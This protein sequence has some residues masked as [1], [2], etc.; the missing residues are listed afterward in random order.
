MSVPGFMDIG[1]GDSISKPKEGGVSRLR[2]SGREKKE[3]TSWS[4]AETFWDFVRVWTF[5]LKE[6]LKIQAC[7]S[8]SFV[9]DVTWKFYSFTNKV[10]MDH[11]NRPSAKF[12]GINLEP[13]PSTKRRIP[14]IS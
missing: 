10:T 8:G 2:F 13:S 1:F 6:F 11:F 3:N 12:C 4:G 9:G 7:L 14:W 5:I